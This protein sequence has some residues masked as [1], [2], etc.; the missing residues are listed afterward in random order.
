[1]SV[2]LSTSRIERSL[3]KCETI[4]DEML[5]F[6][7]PKKFQP[8]TVQV[9][10]W[11]ASVLEELPV[12][13]GIQL[14]RELGLPGVAASIDVNRLRR[15]IVNVYEN[16]CQAMQRE[17]PG[18]APK[19]SKLTVRTRQKGE[20]VE[21]EIADTGPGLDAEGLERIFEP[22]Y[23]TKVN[24]VGLG[25]L[26]VKQTVEQHGGGVEVHSAEGEGARVV[27]WLPSLRD[28]AQS[29]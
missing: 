18:P 29:A 12:P 23:S 15:A 26:V 27:L 22:L 9:D 3:V 11:L 2:W 24:G 19:G 1:M 13:D 16:A 21:L 6:T 10:E 14:T 8:E 17:A 7:R 25:M 4:L 20:R 28:S 5:D